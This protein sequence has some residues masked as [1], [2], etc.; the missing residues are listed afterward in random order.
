MK[1]ILKRHLTRWRYLV[2]FLVVAG[3]ILAFESVLPRHYGGLGECGGAQLYGVR[4]SVLSSLYSVGA[5]AFTVP[6]VIMAPGST[7]RVNV[8]YIDTTAA[9]IAQTNPYYGLNQNLTR[10]P[11]FIGYLDQDQDTNSTGVTITHGPLIS[12]AN[13]VSQ[14]FTIKAALTANWATYPVGGVG[15]LD[16]GG[17]LLTVGVLPYWQP[18]YWVTQPATPIAC[19]AIA[20]FL[21]ALVAGL[22]RLLHRIGQMEIR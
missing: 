6:Q 12:H 2:L 8:T 7:A 11:F 9:E 20:A 5:P 19:L 10:L 22:V 4:L 17:F 13:D 18:V 15:C 1:L 3:G 16:Q 14:I 21:V